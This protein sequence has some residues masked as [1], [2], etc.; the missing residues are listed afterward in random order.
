MN[1]C[2]S[3]DSEGTKDW[4]WA[5]RAVT[6]VSRRGLHGLSCLERLWVLRR[7][8]RSA[9]FPGEQKVRPEAE[10]DMCSAPVP[11]DVPPVPDSSMELVGKEL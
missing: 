5:P 10:R 6:L 3:G 7:P 2:P 9:G 1:S 11:L 8:Q 4:A